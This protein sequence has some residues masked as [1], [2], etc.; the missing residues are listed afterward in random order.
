MV[1][2]GIF[3]R[4]TPTGLYSH[5][6][7][8]RQMDD[9]VIILIDYDN[10]DEL[11]RRR[12][13]SHV[14]R[15]LLDVLSIQCG[16][17]ERRALCRMYGGW[18]YGTSL[19]RR[20]Q[21]LITEL[22]H[23][24]PC[25]MDLVGH[26]EGQTM[27]V[28]AE[29]ARALACDTSIELTH[30]YRRRSIPPSL[31]CKRLPFRGCRLPAQCP[32]AVIDPFIYEESCTVDRCEVSPAEVLIREEQ[33]MVDSMLIVDLIHFAETTDAQLV[34]VSADDDFWPGIR[35][36]LLRGARVIH[37]VSRRKQPKYERYR[38]LKTDSYTQVKI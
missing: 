22:S 35:F 15:C 6:P 37:V 14:M 32:I 3:G 23:D 27:F 30:T 18:F 8:L 13:L 25:T 1:R 11:M 10:L 31:R 19:S 38:R 28:Q 33:K 2:L 34:V 24:F 29:L 12:G 21:R 26:G 16:V 7:L 4:L 5:H 17:R 9:K 36:V 20:A